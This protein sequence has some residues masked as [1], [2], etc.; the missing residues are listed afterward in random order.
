M[1]SVG[2]GKMLGIPSLN[3]DTTTN[4]FCK[5]MY[6][7][8]VENL[9]CRSCYSMSMLKTFRKNCTPK[10]SR[11]SKYLSE[12]VQ[13]RKTLPICPN[14]VGRFSSHGELINSNHLENL[15]NICLNQPMTTFTLW[16]KRKDIVNRVLKNIK[17]P[18]NL[19]LVYSNPIINKLD[20][21]LP[22]HFDKVFNNVKSKTNNVNCD[23][24]CLDCMKCYTLGEPT[25]QIIE[26]IK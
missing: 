18:K 2:S 20:V 21:K 7:S 3:T 15:I 26:V 13:D 5:S 6:N 17:K 8:K 16:T 12:K 11:N 19:I 14:M 23:S 9:I 22:K 4:E 1:W 24:K 25:T 10:F